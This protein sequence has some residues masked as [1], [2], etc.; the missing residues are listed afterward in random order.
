VN[1]HLKTANHD[2]TIA[3]VIALGTYACT[4]LPLQVVLAIRCERLFYRDLQQIT[5][6]DKMK[7]AGTS[8]HFD[9]ETIVTT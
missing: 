3:K 6:H 4:C 5:K 2:A 7:Y 8:F 9:G 1:T